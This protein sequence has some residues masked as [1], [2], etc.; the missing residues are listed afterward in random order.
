MYKLVNGA[1]VEYEEKPIPPRRV[2]EPCTICGT[3]KMLMTLTEVIGLE[4]DFKMVKGTLGT[5]RRMCNDC[6]MQ[7]RYL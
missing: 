4:I 3:T 6:F 2:P 1:W 7:K 5:S